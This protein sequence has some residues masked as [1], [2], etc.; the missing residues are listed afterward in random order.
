M[1]DLWSQVSKGLR[2]G[3]AGLLCQS[4]GLPTCD[5]WNNIVGAFMPRAAASCCALT[6][7]S[8]PSSTV[9]SSLCKPGSLDSWCAA[10]AGA[11]F[12]GRALGREGLLPHRDQRLQ[13]RSRRRLQPGHRAAVRLR[14]PCH[15]GARLQPRCGRH[16]A[17]RGHPRR[18]FIRR[19]GHLCCLN[20]AL[21]GPVR[22]LL[23]IVLLSPLGPL[24]QGACKRSL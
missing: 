7:L 6:A 5:E 14:C 3:P 24:R 10:Q 21:T 9:S 20:P 18:R 2:T 11:Q 15:L 22:G 13:G 23:N 4:R 8:Q 19:C 1:D 12:V 17:A 16:Q